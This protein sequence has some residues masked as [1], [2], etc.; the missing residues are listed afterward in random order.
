[1]SLLDVGVDS[2]QVF[3]QIS[4]TDGYNNTVLVPGTVP[5]EVECRVQP[6]AAADVVG[7]LVQA[8]YRIVAR[9]FPRGPFSGIHWDGRDWDIVGEPRR[10]R[11]SPATRHVT[12]FIK[13]RSPEVA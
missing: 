3:P 4:T 7:Q 5:M 12:V 6:V 13:S 10:H 1:M 8:D 9:D 11:G 2:V